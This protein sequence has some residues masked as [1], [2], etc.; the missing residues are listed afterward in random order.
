MRK[1]VFL[2]A[3]VVA[4]PAAMVLAQPPN[5]PLRRPDGDQRRERYERGNPPPPGQR[6]RPGRYNGEDGN[7]DRFG[8]PPNP[9]L[10]LL[11]K[12]RDGEVS[13]AELDNAESSIRELDRDGDGTLSREELRPPHPPGGD[14]GGAARD[15]ERGDARGGPADRG[16]R[17]QGGRDR[18]PP[19]L[20]E[21]DRDGDGQITPLELLPEPVRRMFEQSDTNGDGVLDAD[22][23]QQAAQKLQRGDRGRRPQPG[24][25]KP[26]R[27][28][29]GEN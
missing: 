16:G 10:H 11:D 7:A 5:G 4:I 27:R 20:Q 19:P 22:E 14:R 28:D 3:A 21:Q 13:A 24:E 29:A 9:I 25:R 23:T 8:P 1:S 26:P 6:G 18:N 2:V 12:D 15:R 17:G